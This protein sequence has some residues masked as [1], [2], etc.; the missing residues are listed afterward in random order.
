M[1]RR[2][3]RLWNTQARSRA[4]RGLQLQNL[5]THDIVPVVRLSLP[6]GH[7]PG[8]KMLCRVQASS[9]AGSVL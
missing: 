2:L 5:S 7:K 9:S 8:R 6:Y 3:C 1:A 4:M